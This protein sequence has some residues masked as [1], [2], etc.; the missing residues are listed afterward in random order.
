MYTPRILRTPPAAG[1][2][3]H[4]L[5]ERIRIHS[6]AAAAEVNLPARA[7]DL[8]TRLKSDSAFA[9]VKIDRLMKPESF[10]GLSAQQVDKFLKATI[11]PLLRQHRGIRRRD[12]EI[13][14]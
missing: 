13:N 4:E 12:P 5:H 14:V 8:L 6:P 9:R 1:G 10:T 2:D 3:R 11:A 7:N